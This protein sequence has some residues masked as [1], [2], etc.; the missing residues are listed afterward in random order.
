[1]TKIMGRPLS[2]IAKEIRQCW[3]RPNFGAV[4]Y[5]DAMRQLDRITDKY[6]QDDARTIV[7]Y[8][9]SNAQTWR[10]PDAKRIKDEL[11][12]MVEP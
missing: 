11:K 5:I 10:G 9:L 3:S 2:A 7:L 8:F 1:M 12:A 4:P 6:G